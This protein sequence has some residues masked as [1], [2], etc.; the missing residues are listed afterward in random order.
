MEELEELV[1]VLS[2]SFTLASALASLSLDSLSSDPAHPRKGR[3]FATGG[4]AEGKEGVRITQTFFGLACKRVG[5]LNP[6]TVLLR[7]S[8][9]VGNLLCDPFFQFSA[10]LLLECGYVC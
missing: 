10:L 1:E 3:H 4:D 7:L 2:S 9:Q 5:T 6:D 8:F